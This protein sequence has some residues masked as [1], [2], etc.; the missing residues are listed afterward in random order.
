MRRYLNIPEQGVSL[1]IVI[2]RKY[3]IYH[4]EVVGEEKIEVP[5]GSFRALHLRAPGAK[6]L[7]LW[8]AYDYSMLPVKIRFDD[9]QYILVQTATKIQLNPSGKLPAQPSPP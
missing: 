5:A 4:I 9:G 3:R 8:L 7:D 6:A 2:A 1:P